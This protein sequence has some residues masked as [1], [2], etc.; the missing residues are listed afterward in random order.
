MLDTIVRPMTHICLKLHLDNLLLWVVLGNYYDALIALA[1]CHQVHSFPVS[2]SG[3]LRSL[4]SRPSWTSSEHRAM[5]YMSRMRGVGGKGE[6]A[7][8]SHNGHVGH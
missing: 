4:G 5:S 1:V 8:T 7:S 2:P 3:R 6:F